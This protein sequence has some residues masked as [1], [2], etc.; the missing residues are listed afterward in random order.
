MTTFD[1]AE[2]QVF[3][4][5]LNTGM[6]RCDSGEGTGCST[7]DDT[8]AFY[9]QLCR[10]FCGQ[11]QRWADAVF[12]GRSKFDAEVERVLRA[13]G[14]RLY[15]RALD[16]SRYGRQMAA[17]SSLPRESHV[18]LHEALL[19]LDRLLKGWVTPRLAVGPSAKQW[20]YPVDPSVIEEGRQRIAELP[21]LPADWEPHDPRLRALYR[22]MRSS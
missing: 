3:A 16:I 12:S 22:K 7:L 9:A 1:L 11:I 15:A 21:P 17:K 13:E 5:D 14:S 8:L 4:A 2:V 18:A 6:D 19:D 10:D 20:R